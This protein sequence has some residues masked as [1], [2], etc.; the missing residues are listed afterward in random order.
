MYNITDS[1]NFFWEKNSFYYLFSHLF[2][3]ILPVIINSIIFFRSLFHNF[4][5]KYLKIVFLSSITWLCIFYTISKK[6][7]RIFVQKV[8]NKTIGE[9]YI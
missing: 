5:H 6:N 1:I 9:F 3:F 2:W 8:S 4:I 7:E